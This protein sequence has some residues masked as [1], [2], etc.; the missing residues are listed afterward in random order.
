MEKKNIEG[1]FR[2]NPDT[3]FCQGSE[4]RQNEMQPKLTIK[5]LYPG[6]TEEE[7]EEAEKN[8]DCYLKLMFK[9][10]EDAFGSGYFS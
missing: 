3:P 9:V 8:L 7:L 1:T 2:H 4:K 5:D 6:L 10:F